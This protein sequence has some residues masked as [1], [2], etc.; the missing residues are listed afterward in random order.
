M[1][2]PAVPLSLRDGL[3]RMPNDL[4]CMTLTVP[5][6]SPATVLRQEPRMTDLLEHPGARCLRSS[7]YQPRRL[8]RAPDHEGR[9][10]RPEALPVPAPAPAGPRRAAEPDDGRQREAV[11]IPRNMLYVNP[12]GVL[13]GDAHAPDGSAPGRRPRLHRRAAARRPRDRPR[14]ADR[15]RGARPR[16]D[17]RPGRRRDDRVGLQ[18]LA[19]GDLAVGRRA[20]SAATIVVG[21]QDPALAAQGDPAQRRRPSGS[22][23]CCCR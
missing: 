22:W 8:R 4:L 16:R 15:R 7:R 1:L 17:A 23:R 13:R 21:A 12:A 10:G 6:A 20:L 2:H 9:H 18:R 3:S 5:A 19:R 14:R 11:S